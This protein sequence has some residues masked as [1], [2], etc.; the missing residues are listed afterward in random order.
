MTTK[1]FCDNLLLKQLTAIQEAEDKC[2]SE[3]RGAGHGLDFI[4]Y[5]KA[6]GCT[7]FEGQAWYNSKW[8][9]R[10]MFDILFDQDLITIQFGLVLTDK[11][12]KTLQELQEA[13]K[14]TAKTEEC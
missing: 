7:V 2:I 3:G 5:A 8:A 11:G 13:A 4:G 9:I 14:L 6:C 1:E 10:K 12:R